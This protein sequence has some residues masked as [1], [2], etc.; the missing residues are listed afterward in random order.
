MRFTRR[1]EIYEKLEADEQRREELKRA[2]PVVIDVK[3]VPVRPEPLPPA[4]RCSMLDPDG[5][6]CDLPPVRPGGMCARHLR[7]NNIYPTALP[8]PE[9]ALGLQEM[10]GYA[11]VC[12]IDKM[13]DGKQA[14]AIAQLGR[15]MEKNL[16]RCERQREEIEWRRRMLRAGKIDP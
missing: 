2:G 16:A 8:F 15:V 4:E 13:F 3:H 5:Q 6:Q 12:T 1:I 11:V 10:M 7:W 14:L 9:T